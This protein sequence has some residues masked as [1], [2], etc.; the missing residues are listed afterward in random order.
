MTGEHGGLRIPAVAA[1]A[2]LAGG[3]AAGGPP[4]AAPE[5]DVLGATPGAGRPDRAAG[6]APGSGTCP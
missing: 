1:V 2:G 3:S 5:C 4:R 6:A